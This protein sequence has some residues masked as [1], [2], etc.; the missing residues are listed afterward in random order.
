MPVLDP[1]KAALTDHLQTLVK[2]VSL[3]SSGH[4]S[5]SRNGGGGNI[6]FTKTAQVQRIDE[7]TVSISAMF[8]SQEISAQEIKEIVVHGD[9]ALDTPS[10]RTTFLPIRKNGTNEI[11]VDVLMEVR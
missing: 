10:Y 9:N 5:S 8:D 7:R 2:K 11:R 4:S 1:L 3:G 6:Q